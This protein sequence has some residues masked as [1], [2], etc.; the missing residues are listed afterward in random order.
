M[1]VGLWQVLTSRLV[2]STPESAALSLAIC[3]KPA[4]T[5]LTGSDE[6]PI[7]PISCWPWQIE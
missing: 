6:Y 7:G 3:W 1:N 5:R 2:R 4:C